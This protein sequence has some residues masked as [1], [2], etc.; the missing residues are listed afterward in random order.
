MENLAEVIRLKSLPDSTADKGLRLSDKIRVSPI[1]GIIRTID[2][3]RTKI[4]LECSNEHREFLVDGVR[5]L[6]PSISPKRHRFSLTLFGHEHSERAARYLL[7]SLC[8]APFKLNG[9]TVFKAFIERGDV[10]DLDGSRIKI[11]A[12]DPF[13][14]ESSSLKEE[15]IQSNLPILIEGET[16]TGK[17]RLA[18][19][20]HK[21]SGV[22]GE[23]V[24]L[25]LLSFSP[26][27]I[28]SELFGHV[29]GAFTGAHVDKRGAL[30]VA[31]QG[32]L[33]LDEV[34]SLPVDL[35]IKLLLFLDDKKFRPVGTLKEEKSSA[36]IICASGRPL[37]NLVSNG[38]FR[39]DFYYRIASGA[40]VHLSPLREKKAEVE[41]LVKGYL[42][43][44]EMTM[45]KTLLDFYQ[46][47]LWPGNVRQLFGHL[48]K[49]KI[50]S[51]GK[52]LIL[53]E[54]DYPLMEGDKEMSQE[55]M[56]EFVSLETLKENY[57]YRT[58][59]YY[60]RDYCLAA[61]ALG[62]SK[63]TVRNMIADIEMRD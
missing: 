28:E 46:S 14:Q 34:D 44:N 17:S 23:F 36:R 48:E 19:E 24:H 59:L 2:L 5:W 55:T 12:N 53:D 56:H 32:T 13:A 40:H 33:F 31:H 54:T 16:G 43:E 29:R 35:Q 45:D 51:N 49:K 47:L 15:I 6:L 7:E 1:Y 3:N 50:L 62:I 22:F 25:N 61:V 57:V 11:Q 21:R 27:L 38:G 26:S 37:K 30:T 60:D 52:R 4:I 10:V 63:N 20:I 18:K 42:L 39:K 58:F 9:N 8:E 41:L